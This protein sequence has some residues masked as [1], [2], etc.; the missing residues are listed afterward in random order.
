MSRISDMNLSESEGNGHG[1]GAMAA[2]GKKLAAAA[3]GEFH[4]FIADIEDLITS[5]TP[6]TGEDLAR[7]K[8]KLA[9]RVEL[10]KES[11]AEAGGQIADRARQTARVT[12]AYVR[13]NPW[14]SIGIGAILGLLVG[15]AVSRRI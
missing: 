15:I 2:T 7:A 13:E 1:V 3:P 9:E 10:A 8:A 11:F 14:T 5:M 4:N 12:D 6:L